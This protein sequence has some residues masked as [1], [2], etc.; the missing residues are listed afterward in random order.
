MRRQE[1]QVP[2][3]LVDVTGSG[4]RADAVRNRKAVLDAAGTLLLEQGDFSMSEL[5]RVAGITRPTL[6]RHFP[7]RSCVLDAVAADLGP[8]IIGQ[9]LDA[10]ERLPLD[11]ALERLA[12][13]VVGVAAD[14]RHVLDLQHRGVDDLARLIVPD[15]PI[16]D[17]LERRRAT[18]ELADDLDVGWLSRAVRA[19]CLTAVV[20]DRHRDVVAADLARSLRA[21]A[22]V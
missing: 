8:A 2:T 11:E 6:Y 1:T 5:A 3:T 9:I 4:R 20:D 13:D 17:F 16:A 18:G 21:V 14:H 10:F 19:L 12:A 15:E 7:D 22:G